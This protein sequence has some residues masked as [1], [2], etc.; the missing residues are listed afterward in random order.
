METVEQKVEESSGCRFDDAR[1]AGDLVT[2]T[3]IPDDANPES[4]DSVIG[5][6]AQY[7]G[8]CFKEKALSE[9]V[10][11]RTG[12]EEK[13]E[14]VTSTESTEKT[15]SKSAKQTSTDVTQNNVMSNVKPTQSKV[16][17]DDW[18]DALDISTLKLE[19]PKNENEVIAADGNGLT[20]KK[21]S[22]DFLLKFAAQCTHLLEEFEVPFDVDGALLVSGVDVLR[23]SYPSPG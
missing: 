6:S 22:R 23:E 9:H 1:V 16:E 11:K 10:T 18:E 17:P 5:E 20:T 21:Y 3:S 7:D 4:S 19:T 13:K 15:T 8:T 12:P 2:P 14:N